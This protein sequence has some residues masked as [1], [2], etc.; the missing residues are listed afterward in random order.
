M[1]ITRSRR[2]RNGWIVAFLVLS[3]TVTLFAH[4]VSVV[5]HRSS[6]VR[7]SENS[8]FVAL[9]NAVIASD[10]SLDA[11]LASLIRG[12]GAS[13][14]MA[15]LIGLREANVELASIEA[16]A[17]LLVG[18]T[19]SGGLDQQLATDIEERSTAYAQ[20]LAFVA[21]AMQFPWTRPAP[22]LPG[23]AQVVLATTSASWGS[24]RHLLEGMPGGATLAP[25]SSTVATLPLTNDLTALS[26]RSTF[27]LTRDFRIAALAI[28]PA[29]LQ[30]PRG[31]LSL[32]PVSSMSV[33][34]ALDNLAVDTQT[35]IVTFTV[36]STKGTSSTV[37]RSA[38]IG[39]LNSVGLAPVT[40]PLVAGES[41]R[42]TV[43][44]TGNGV[45]RTRTYALLVAPPVPQG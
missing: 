27:V 23:P 26:T 19:V 34:A 20:L 31:T 38:I 37:T 39:P 22:P 8:S 15:F 16:R 3:V 25:L 45:T 36:T 40:L 24:S 17:A 28:Q 44:A 6:G 7:S 1:A 21:G 10:N 4:Q 35:V 30:A 32:P 41:G 9:A 18:P 12:T 11:T 13:T 2:R 14:R 42:L 5:A 29:P 43:T 33:T